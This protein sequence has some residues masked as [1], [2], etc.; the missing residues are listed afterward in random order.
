MIYLYSGTPGAGKSLHVAR[1]IT[2]HLRSGRPVIANF[3][4]DYDMIS[5][6]KKGEYLE[7]DNLEISPAF[8]VSCSN[9]LR[10][11]QDGNL[12]EGTILLVIDESQIL[13][14]SR[15]WGQ[16]N[17]ASWL[18]FFSQHRKLGYDVILVSQYDRMLDRQI[19]ALVEYEFKHRKVKNYGGFG[20]LLSMLA[21]GSLFVCVEIWYPLK[22][23]VGS[24]F[25]I[26]R[27]KY[28]RLYDTFKMF[29]APS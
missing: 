5:G 27:K 6:R 26:A 28:Y 25:F 11:A 8:L 3:P 23:K 17:R 10:L 18:S 4:V 15:D 12:K 29:N 24:Q 9:A 2:Q 21:G 22:Q 20:F 19:R 16:K 7:V 13:F 1:V 14:N